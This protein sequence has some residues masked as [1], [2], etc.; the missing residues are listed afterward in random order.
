[1]RRKRGILLF[2]LC[3]LVLAAPGMAR[4]EIELAVS[5]WNWQSGSVSTLTGTARCTL[6]GETLTLGVQVVADPAADE[7]SRAVFVS[8]GGKKIAVRNQKNEIVWTP[9]GEDYPFEISWHLSESSPSPLSATVQIYLRREDGSLVEQKEL[10]IDHKTY[11]NKEG[12]QIVIT[13]DAGRIALWIGLAAL[14]VWA[15]VILRVV[16]NRKQERK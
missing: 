4:G 3:F 5:D 7:N 10:L 9:E 14:V 1:M 2:L 16:M 11:G 12:N 13:L 15:V 6:A 8:A